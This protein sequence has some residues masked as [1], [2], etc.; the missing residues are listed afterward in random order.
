MEQNSNNKFEK[1]NSQKINI[2][3]SY[4]SY[5]SS[6][7]FLPTPASVAAW[8]NRWTFSPLPPPPLLPSNL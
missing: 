6:L 8:V 1:S 3:K 7:L 5:F 4:P 2:I